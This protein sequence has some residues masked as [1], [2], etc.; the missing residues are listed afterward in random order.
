MG[1]FTFI[2]L[3]VI[4]ITLDPVMAEFGP[5]TLTW[6]GLFTAV[7]IL[8]GV[9]LSVWLAKKDGIPETKSF[10]V[11]CPPRSSRPLVLRVRTLD[12]F[13]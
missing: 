9:S 2:P 13:A 5:F 1:A 4:K 10:L 7:G 11:A 3:L 6:H 8:G 12:R